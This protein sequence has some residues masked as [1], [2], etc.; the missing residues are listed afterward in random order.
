[1]SNVI[2]PIDQ[3][4]VYWNDNT[5]EVVVGTITHPATDNSARFPCWICTGNGSVSNYTETEAIADLFG[6]LLW[7]WECDRINL[8]A[9]L[10]EVRKIKGV[11]EWLDNGRIWI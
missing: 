8:K 6:E 9:A 5:G 3:A 4:R 10:K 7:L 11:S 1:M 2:I